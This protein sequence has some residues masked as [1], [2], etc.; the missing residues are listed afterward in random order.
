II[1]PTHTHFP[2]TTLFRSGEKDADKERRMTDQLERTQPETTRAQDELVD[3]LHGRRYTKFARFVFAALGSIPGI[4]GFIAASAALHRSE[5]H[6][7]EL[8][9]RVDLVC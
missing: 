1:L 7:S 2:Y 5:E 4:G 6:T 3:F 8:Q 9:S